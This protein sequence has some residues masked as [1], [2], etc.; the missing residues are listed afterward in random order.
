MRRSFLS[1]PI[2]LLLAPLATSQGTGDGG[3]D[4]PNNEERITQPG[5]GPQIPFDEGRWEFWWYYNREPLIGLRPALTALAAGNADVDEPFQEVTRGDREESVVPLLVRAIRDSNPFIRQ[6]AVQALAKS[7][8]PGAR[9]S[10]FAALRDELFQVRLDSI[11]ALGVWGDT[12][13]L[14]RL[15]AIV[16]DSKREL[17]ERMYAALAIGMIGGPLASESLK[18][19]LPPRV[20]TEFPIQVQNGIA[21]AVGLTADPNSVPL[22]QTLLGE[23]KIQ[24]FMVR[25]HLVLSIGRCGTPEAA[26]VLLAA[27]RSDDMQQRRSAA[28]ALGRLLRKSAD[29]TAVTALA[30]A[31]HGDNDLTVRNF[32]FIS[33]GYVGGKQAAE[34]LRADLA[35]VTT[36]SRGFV[37]LALGLLGDPESVPLLLTQFQRENDTSLKAALSIS[38]GLHRDSRAAPVLRKALREAKE[39]V[40]RGYVALALGLLGDVESI[41]QLQAAFK[42]ASD[43]ELISNTA[44][45]LGLLGDRT[46]AVRL[47]ELAK[48]EKSEF[49]RQSL[50]FAMGLIG[51]RSAIEL[52]GSVVRQTD[53]VSYIRGYAVVA[54]GL[55]SD[56]QDVRA[57]AR[58]STDSNY[59]IVSDFL[60][61]VFRIL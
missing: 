60:N 30:A 27:L 10:L 40:F 18:Q 28:I 24:D 42:G 46:S 37:A 23:Q 7:Q 17:Q 43:V 8:D 1:I 15:E 49:V 13:S 11:V 54:L 41:P 2:L 48:A 59:T 22:L 45:A 50:L 57:I 35:K 32:C 3:D 53:E 52:L 25:S 19:L 6:A 51:D 14:P 12:V 33:L 9:P 36:A 20:F 5:Q 4:A 39:P 34:T 31:A 58:V 38:L 29:K 61:D 26:P 55:L 16:R 44:T 47:A 56:R 21:Y